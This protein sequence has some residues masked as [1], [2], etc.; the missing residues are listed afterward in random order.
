MKN[1]SQSYGAA[2]AIWNHTLPP[3][4]GERDPPQP[5]PDRPA[6]SIYVYPADRWKAERLLV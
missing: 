6:Y 3:D 2:S 4:T 1:A 5:K